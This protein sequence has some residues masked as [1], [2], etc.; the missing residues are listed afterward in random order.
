M[1]EDKL[2]LLDF[3]KIQD[4]LGEMNNLYRFS[5]GDF[6][7][8]RSFAGVKDIATK[9]MCPG[10]PY[11]LQEGRIIFL[12]QGNVRICLNLRERTYQAP[13]AVLLSPGTVGEMIDFSPDCDF[14]ILAFRDTFME[15]YRQDNLI[16]AYYLR[17]L[18]LIIPLLD[19]DRNRMETI[20]NLLWDV[21]HDT[22]WNEDI[23]KEMILLIFKQIEIYR[24]RYL[25][26]ENH[27]T[28]PRE[29]ILEHFINL[30]NEY[31]VRKRNI[32]FYADKLCLTPHYLSTIIR[33]SSGQTIMNW[34]NRAVIQEAQILL[35]HTNLQV[36]QIADRLHFPNASFFCK[37]FRRLTSMSPV[38][39]R[40][41]Y[42]NKPKE[43]HH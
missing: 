10:H 25:T 26:E 5:Q 2:Q 17:R 4:I 8:V 43:L 33:Q 9:M 38:E 19:T 32:A 36:T 34:I 23:V 30:V 27:Q 13:A 21:L 35:L 40:E 3:D 39:Y 15:N 12:R 14:A 41:T 37:Y 20:L 11:R 22:P 31:A 7:F 24:Q 16:R 18:C 29:E 1:N 42:G 6:G 28:S